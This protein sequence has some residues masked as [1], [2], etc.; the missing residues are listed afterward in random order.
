MCVCFLWA[1]RDV[2]GLGFRNITAAVK[3]QLAKNTEHEL[4]LLGV[5]LC[6]E[7]Q[8]ATNLILG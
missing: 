8:I 3:N 1:Y 5:M 7:N 4:H 6:R 2:Y